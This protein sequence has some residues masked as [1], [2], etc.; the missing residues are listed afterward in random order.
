MKTDFHIH[1]HYS[2][3][4]HSV[5]D[6]LEQAKK[7]GLEFVS[8]SDHNW[9][10][11]LDEKSKIASDIGIAHIEGIEISARYNETNIHILGY[12]KKFDKNILI[13]GLNEQ[14]KGF[15]KRAREIVEKINA[16]KI[17]YID[18]DEMSSRYKGCI[19]N[20]PIMI[21]IAENLKL[22]LDDAKSIYKKFSLPYGDWHLNVAEAI[23]LIHKAGGIAVLA[24]P[25]LYKRKFG[26]DEFNSL[27]KLALDSGIDG[28]ESKHSDQSQEEEIEIAKLAF[29]N[30]LITT[31]GSDFHGLAIHPHRKIGSKSIDQKELD[32]FLIR[33]GK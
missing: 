12:S 22:S 32:S 8:L 23:D 18:F 2:D 31:G 27:F 28:L 17:T 21:F 5:K 6:T 25:F 13:N 33:L 14:L 26:D 20:F 15:D 11:N 10:Y 9:P 24:H 4:Q 7:A 1:T 3:G 16:S 29:A 19:Q 30:G